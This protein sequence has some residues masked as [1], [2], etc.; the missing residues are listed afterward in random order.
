MSGEK[1]LR[2]REPGSRSWPCGISNSLGMAMLMSNREAWQGRRVQQFGFG[3]HLLDVRA[4]FSKDRC[5]EVVNLLAVA[6]GDELNA[7]IV[8]VANETSDLEIAGQ[9]L[10]GEAEAHP[11]DPTREMDAATLSKHSIR[12]AEPVPDRCQDHGLQAVTP[13]HSS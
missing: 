10:T 6:L 1:R 13:A 7:T 11:L 8:K 2:G 12:L 9:G 4:H 5:Q 3:V